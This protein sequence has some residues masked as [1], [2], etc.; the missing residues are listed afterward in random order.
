M[1]V[2]GLLSGEIAGKRRGKKDVMSAAMKAKIA[3][4]NLV[5]GAVA[6]FQLRVS[7]I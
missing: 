3:K 2:L 6:S 4:A 7:V 5:T 1:D